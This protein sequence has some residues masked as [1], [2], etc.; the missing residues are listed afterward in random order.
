MTD[1]GITTVN[2]QAED[3]S[4]NRTPPHG[5]FRGFGTLDVSLFTL[6]QHAVNGF[7]PA[8]TIL[9]IKT[10]G[11]KIGPYLDA[12]ADGT[13]TAVGI[14]SASV[15]VKNPDGTSKTLIGVAYMKHGVVSIARL[16]FTSGTA[17]AGGYIDAN[18][19]ADLARIQ[20][21]A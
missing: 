3:L 17:A 2:E 9:G 20:F 18:G 15:Q 13:Q 11:G 12:A 4:W 14:L 19:Q 10:T 8:G 16:P 6:A 1:I 5:E 21:D 7:I